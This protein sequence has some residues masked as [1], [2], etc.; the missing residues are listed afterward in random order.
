M[1]VLTVNQVIEILLKF[2][3]NRDWRTSFFEVVPQRKRREIDSVENHGE[4]EGE[5][6]Q[7]NDHQLEIKKQ[8]VEVPSHG[9]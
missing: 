2:L 1:Q 8:C 6:N 5:A 4:V 7:E 9:L 3:E